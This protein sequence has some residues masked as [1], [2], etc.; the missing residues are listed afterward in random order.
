MLFQYFDR[1]SGL[2]RI[3]SV[4]YIYI[5]LLFTSPLL[6]AVIVRIVIYCVKILLPTEQRVGTW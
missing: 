3:P 4:Y 6:M 1:A 5:V 2:R